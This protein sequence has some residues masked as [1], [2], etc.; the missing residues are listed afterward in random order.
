M[1]LT[2]APLSPKKG[3][4]Y[5][6]AAIPD[7]RFQNGF[8]LR[9]PK[10][11][12]RLSRILGPAY[13]ASHLLR[14]EAHIDEVLCKLFGWMDKFAAE[15][16]P[17]DLSHFLGYAAYDVVGEVFF[18][19]SFGFVDQGRDV[20][21]TLAAAKGVQA[22]GAILGYFHWLY[23]VLANPV[24]TW[25]GVLPVGFVYNAAQKAVR[26][27]RANPDARFDGLALWLKA[28][29][30]NAE[31]LSLHEV[32]SASTIVVQ[33]GAE[34]VS[35]EPYLFAS[36]FG[37]LLVSGSDGAGRREAHTDILPRRT[38]ELFIPHYA[39]SG[40]VATGSG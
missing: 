38:A 27:R 2:P 21:G 31:R 6:V 37:S 16:K 10:E 11:K 12:M 26:S 9:D 5:E 25:L 29:Q 4:F 14:S 35:C 33:A 13:S 3:P 36:M 30:D 1:K 19:Q 18:S 24:M 20:G 34:T 22:M 8:S 17:M 15:R 40:D 28:S 39:P 32:C 7:W 23:L